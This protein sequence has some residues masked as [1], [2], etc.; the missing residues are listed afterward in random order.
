MEL[1]SACQQKLESLHK[2]VDENFTPLVSV[3]KGRGLILRT[4][5]LLDAESA[6]AMLDKLLSSLSSFVKKEVHDS[7]RITLTLK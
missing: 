4:L 7:V 3:R 6:K 2:L 1:K 5:S